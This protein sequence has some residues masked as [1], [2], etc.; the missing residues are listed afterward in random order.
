[1]SLPVSVNISAYQ[2]QRPDFVEREAN[3]S[4]RNTLALP[5]HAALYARITAVEQLAATVTLEGNRASVTGLTGKL[6]SGGSISG[7]GTIDISATWSGEHYVVEF[8]DT[9][10]GI[11]P[12]HIGR[13]FDPF[14]STKRH[15]SGHG[16]G[17]AFCRRVM[18][19][20]NGRID[21]QSTL[22]AG[23]CFSLSFRRLPGS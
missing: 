19:S 8:R 20:L 14:F 5:A 1:M 16:M 4:Q 6:A 2:L 17:L 13:I 9:G 22:G 11:A 7:S 15:G 12:E 18:E 10:C 21:C 3:L 23:T